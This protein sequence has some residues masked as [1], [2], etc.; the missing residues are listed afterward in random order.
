LR[1]AVA[2][3]RAKILN[4]DGKTTECIQSVREAKRLLST[5]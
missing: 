5:D 3:A 1:F 4:A 2:L